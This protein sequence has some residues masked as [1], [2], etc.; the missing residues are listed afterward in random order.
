MMPHEFFVNKYALLRYILPRNEISGASLRQIP[1]FQANCS[2][3]NFAIWS[4]KHQQ[5]DEKSLQDRGDIL[6][7]ITVTITHTQT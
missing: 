7:V 1:I 4:S 3:S 6:L 5:K 2:C